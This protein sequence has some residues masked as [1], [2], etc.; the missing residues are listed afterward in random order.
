MD[1]GKEVRSYKTKYL[2][3][4]LI[5]GFGFPILATWIYIETNSSV[6]SFMDILK[7]HL[8]DPILRIVDTASIFLGFFAYWTVRQRDDLKR[9]TV[10]SQ[11]KLDQ[12]TNDL[13]I[14]NQELSDQ[15]KQL[16]QLQKTINRENEYWEAIFNTVSDLLIV[17]NTS[18]IIT[19]CNRAAIESFAA[20]V[21]NLVGSSIHSIL[22][23]ELDNEEIP[24][25]QESKIHIG[26]LSGWFD[27][28][29]YFMLPDNGPGE[30]VYTFKNVSEWVSTNEV[31][32]YQKRFYEALFENS[33]VAIITL[34][35]DHN[36]TSYNPAFEELFKYK[37][38]EIIGK[39]LD[40]LLV[41]DTEREQARIFTEEVVTGKTIHGIGQRK[42]EDNSLVDV[43]ILGVPVIVDGKKKGVLAIYHDITDI[44]RSRKEAEIAARVK[45]EFMAN[46]SHEIRTPLN[47]ILGMSSLLLATE[48]SPDQED[49]ASTIR[50]SSNVLLNIVN[51]ILD[52]SKIEAGKMVLEKQTFYTRELIESSLDLLSPYAAKKE[53]ELAY[54]LEEDVPQRVISDP[55][56]LRQ[57]LVNLLNNAIKFTHTG[58]VVLTVANKEK[59]GEE[60]TLLISV[61]DTGI[62]IPKDRLDTLF[63]PF[64]QVDAS[65]TRKYGGTGLG[66][67]ISKNL[68]QNM[69]GEVWVES[70]VGKGT[71]FYFTLIVQAST[72]TSIFEPRGEQ[73]NFKGKQ[74]LIVGDNETNRSILVKLISSWGI[75][76]TA[77]ISAEEAIKE[78]KNKHFDLALIDIHL[79]EA[80]VFT[81]AE[82]LRRIKSKEDLPMILLS[83][84]GSQK[85][86]DDRFKH[87]SAF[88]SKPVKSSQL[89]NML[90]SLIV[91]KPLEP[92]KVKVKTGSLFDV[93]LGKEKPLTILLVEDHLVN[94]K[95]IVKLLEKFGYRPDIASNGIEA[96]E[97]FKRQNYDVIFMDDQ[98][99]EMDGVEAT[100]LIRENWPASQ[101]PWIIAMTAH[102]MEGDRER[103]LSLKM[104]DYLSKPINVDSLVSVI[105][106][107]NLHNNPMRN[108]DEQQYNI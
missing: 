9:I 15:L 105:R 7:A 74:V 60:Y 72:V 79:H 33:P 50:H 87:F 67:A 82:E 77:V 56:R 35:L 101:Q 28:S 63:Q 70:S 40:A 51:D 46:M 10:Y 66:L 32:Q 48:L 69:G 2:L 38:D 106:N 91:E 20:T 21:P 107:V 58:E 103:Y 104:N 76:P 59:K 12:K 11:K 85:L 68:I 71:T 86:E 24:I 49:F 55:T 19:K 18:G 96:L 31:I 3:I 75:L 65:T 98:M 41:P 37:K 25:L 34:D 47:A 102:A 99:P 17:T 73:P 53:I 80:D 64:S 97:A 8:N 83:S 92:V 52:F 93:T 23:N 44:E 27:V 84:L 57:V 5:F 94:Q 16:Q 39:N 90:T 42:R 30:V 29:T 100:R 14:S 36:I 88:L 6:Q 1:T 81:L 43:E 95:V 13:S 45:S 4:G 108:H 89:F 54:I 62:G 78:T 26:R 22:S 61:K